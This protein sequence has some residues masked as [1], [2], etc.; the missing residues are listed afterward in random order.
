MW[1]FGGRAKY[2]EPV[3]AVDSTLGDPVARRLQKA[4]RRGDWPTVRAVFESV[5]HPDDR[6]F[7]VE[8]A[9]EVPRLEESIPEWV[10]AEPG[11]P[12]PL[13][14]QGAR[15]IRWAWESRG[16]GRAHTVTDEGYALF[17]ERLEL[18]ENCL[19]EVAALD[20]GNPEPWAQLVLSG[21]GREV[22]ID[23]TYRRFAEVRRRYRWHLTAHEQ[24]LQQLCRKW[25]GS[26]EL[27]HDFA[28]RTV[29]EMP[30]G[31]SLGELV[32]VAQL[33][34]WLDL[35]RTERRPYLR[36]AAVRAELTAAA[37]RSIRH[38]AYVP[39]ARAAIVHNVF[40]LAFA[41]VGDARS[42]AAQFELIG[43]CVTQWPWEYLGSPAERFVAVRSGARA[44]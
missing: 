16:G 22:G 19:G 17:F 34:R 11:A 12:L 2:A 33:E 29:A 27:M 40:A 24:M 32:A 38:P 7:Y 21:R 20:P 39:P 23:E 30:V 13:L 8:Q 37:D 36:R 42:A 44:G 41:Q 4:L 10:A 26:H 1:L 5:D 25:G 43:D 14:L 28:R 31:S 35:S 6:A 3:L 18:A 9:A 15:A